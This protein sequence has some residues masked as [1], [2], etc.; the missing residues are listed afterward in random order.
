MKSLGYMIVGGNIGIAWAAYFARHGHA[1]TR[2]E[3]LLG[4]G[5]SFVVYTVLV[6][7]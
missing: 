4:L 3:T 1:Y 2:S 6:W 7:A 5:L